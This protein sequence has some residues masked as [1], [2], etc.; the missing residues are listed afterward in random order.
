MQNINMTGKNRTLHPLDP[1][2]AGLLAACTVAVYFNSLDGAF[3]FDDFMYILENNS[4]SPLSEIWRIITC[5]MFRFRP[6]AGLT[7]AANYAISADSTWGYHAVNIAVHSTN[8]VLV[9]FLA[10]HALPL[11]QA[12]NN[13]KDRTA[14][15]P[16]F[17]IALSWALHPLATSAVTYISQRFESL[18]AM[19]ILLTLCFYIKKQPV[20]MALCAIFA[21]T[22]KE[23]AA[24]IALIIPV[25]AYVFETR[26][27][28]PDPKKN[29]LLLTLSFLPAAII[30]GL[31]MYWTG[32]PDT[33]VPWASSP[34]IL[35][36]ETI[37]RTINLPAP[38]TGWENIWQYFIT[39]PEIIL[40]YLKL[41]FFPAGLALDY[42]WELRTNILDALPYFLAVLF[43]FAFTT[44]LLVKRRKPA[45]AGVWFFIFLAPTSSFLPI[46]DAAFE[47][48]MYLPLMAV[49][50]LAVVSIHR[51]SLLILKN[52]T[53][54][55]TFIIAMILICATLG[56]ATFA[57]NED[58]RSES[59]LWQD[60]IEKRPASFRARSNLAGIIAREALSGRA[61]MPPG[62]YEARKKTALELLKTAAALNPD[63]WEE[64]FTLGTTYGKFGEYKEAVHYLFKSAGMNPLR[65]DIFHNL[66]FFLEKSG[67][68]EEAEIIYYKAVQLDP[69]DRVAAAAYGNIVR[70]N[71]K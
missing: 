1:I 61:A 56:A 51:L 59:A 12:A 40:H 32:K 68:F 21:A 48:R 14:S 58:Y 20:A 2:L 66:A 31:Y 39:Q 29:T 5:E 60:N 65:H 50:A 25:W 4:I 13:C 62:R 9:F 70:R 34:S 10:R 7:F 67:R 33:T 54:P 6:L 47:H 30:A 55:R 44:V 53:G 18:S 35:S 43:L 64:Y 11:V 28:R 52:R 41:A 26:S 45:F 38:H 42:S 16:A 17:F 3:V 24:A 8:A 37:L 23:T 71:K 27:S 46:N 19:F 63:N 57:R 69:E 22:S 36:P 15:L 49:C